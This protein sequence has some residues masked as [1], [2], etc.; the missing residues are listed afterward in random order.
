MRLWSDLVQNVPIFQCF[1]KMK[2]LEVSQ[3]KKKIA[4]KAVQTLQIIIFFF[5]RMQQQASA[6]HCDYIWY[7]QSLKYW[8]FFISNI[9]EAIQWRRMGKIFCLYIFKAFRGII[10]NST[11]LYNSTRE[12]KYQFKLHILLFLIEIKSVVYVCYAIRRGHWGPM[13]SLQTLKASQP[14][15]QA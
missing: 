11:K 4:A 1:A 14:R 8:P 13:V 5:V 2:S 12:L 15:L 9:T 10:C 7:K 3:I 6:C